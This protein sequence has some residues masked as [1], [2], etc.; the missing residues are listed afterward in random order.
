MKVFISQKMSG[1]T[2]EEVMAT[3]NKA[4]A[5]LKSMYGKYDGIEIEVLETYFHENVPD[6]AGRIWH[7][8]ESIKM[9][10]K[11]DIVYFCDEWEE[12]NGCIIEREICKLYNIPIYGV[13][14]PRDLVMKRIEEGDDSTDIKPVKLA[15]VPLSGYRGSMFGY[16]SEGPRK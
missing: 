7:L 8:G 14:S 15:S 1:L 5:D 11:A 16:K 9:L 2:E 12:S 3:R 6:D 4:I 13:H 10:E